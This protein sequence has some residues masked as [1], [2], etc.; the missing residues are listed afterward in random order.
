MGLVYL[1]ALDSQTKFA[2]WRIEESDDE[3]LSKLQLDEKEKARLESFAKNKRRKHWLATRVLLRTLL[4]T[5]D[6]IECVSDENGKPYLANFPEKISLSHSF[7]YAAAMISTKGEVGI[8][9]ELISEK[10]ER[11]TTKFLKPEELAFISNST[12]RLPQLYACWSAKEAVYKVQGKH[13]VSFLQNMTIL[14]FDFQ[15]Q[16]ILQML[17]TTK[18][19]DRLLEV[20]Y[21]KFNNYMLCYVVA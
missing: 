6:Y 11:I 12:D 20:H 3:L 18:Y 19:Q 5:P 13:G 8:D 15:N 14:P 16:G 17:L 4:Q 9:M 21:E 7:D 2:I 10:I 1:R